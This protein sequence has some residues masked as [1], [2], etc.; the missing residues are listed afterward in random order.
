MRAGGALG[1]VRAVADGPQ[2]MAIA[3][4]PSR[5][6]GRRSWTRAVRV[7][8]VLGWAAIFSS[9][10]I[11]LGGGA[12]PE[13]APRPRPRMNANPNVGHRSANFAIYAPTPDLARQVAVR[14]EQ[15]RRVLAIEWL[16][17]ELPTWARPCRVQVKVTRGESGGETNFSF[18]RKGVVDQ[19]MK[20]E[21]RIDRIMDSALPHEVTHTILAHVY[22]GPLPRWA[23]EG[24]SL[25]SE[26]RLERDRY[27]QIARRL[28]LE[29]RALPLSRLFVVE[30]YPRNIFDFYG[31]GFSVSTF[32]IEMGGKPRFLRF[33]RDGEHHGW[34]RAAETHYQLPNVRELDRAWR[35]WI[36]TRDRV[37]ARRELSP[38]DDRVIRAQS[39]SSSS[40]RSMIRR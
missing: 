18:G 30:A 37:L 24:A 1:T 17:R 22:G 2:S 12:G 11:A 5:T 28:L 10:E 23:D 26:D 7:W 9:G 27:D 34:D 19:D 29:D 25:G 6:Q 38:P 20:V 32:L 4:I 15:C 36:K 3:G 14:A 33:L 35:A 8:A 31:Q 16:G 21:G 13:S 39:P 40:A